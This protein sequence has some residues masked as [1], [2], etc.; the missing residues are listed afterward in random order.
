MEDKYCKIRV[1]D[2]KNGYV[3]IP[4]LKSS[5]DDTEGVNTSNGYVNCNVKTGTNDAN[6]IFIYWYPKNDKY[7][8]KDLS[9]KLVGVV[10]RNVGSNNNVSASR[11]P[12]KS[13]HYK[14]NSKLAN[15]SLDHNTGVY[16]FDVSVDNVNQYANTNSKVIIQTSTD[17][18]NWNNYKEL[19]F[20]PSV[21]SKKINEIDITK[22]KN[23][24]KL[25]T[26]QELSN[27]H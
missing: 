16:S 18:I 26:A 6:H 15:G 2:Y 12:V 25:F 4:F 21:T 5:Y 14:Y 24:N 17:S 19:S 13:E 10:K 22:Y 20:N 9:F 11:G 8:N 3:D 27:G 7:V 1:D 23:K